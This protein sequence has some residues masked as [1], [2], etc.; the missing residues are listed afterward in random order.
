[1]HNDDITKF[2]LVMV[3]IGAVFLAPVVYLMYLLMYFVLHI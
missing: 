3:S 2:D 1:M